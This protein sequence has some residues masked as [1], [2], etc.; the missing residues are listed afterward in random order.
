MKGTLFF[1]VSKMVTVMK[2]KRK[3]VVP[4]E[5]LCEYLKHTPFDQYLSP[6]TLT[7]F[8]SCFDGVIKSR[9]GK[10]IAL[11]SHKVYV[12]CQGEVDLSTVYPEVEGKVEAKGFLCRK[13]C[14]DIINVTQTEQDVKRRM[15]IKVGKAIDV[16]EEIITTGSGESDIILV[17]STMKALNDFTAVHPELAAPIKAICISSIEDR[18][19]TIS[20]LEG[21][22]RSKLNVLAAMCRY[23]AFDAN[24]VVFN[25]NSVGTKLYLVLSG[26]A[27]VVAKDKLS[28]S[29]DVSSLSRP[30]SSYK[31][32]IE[33]SIVLQRSFECGG[34]QTPLLSSAGEVTIAELSTGSFFGETALVF[35][36]GRTCSVKTSE[37]SLFLT[38]DR[39][40]FRNFLRICSTIEATLTTSIKKR[41]VS[42]LSSLGIPFLTGIPEE[43]LTSLATS[44]S[45]QE[46]PMDHIIFRQGDVGDAFYIIVHGSVRVETNHDEGT[47]LGTLGPGQYFG[48]MSILFSDE[49]TRNATVVVSSDKAILL[50]IDKDSFQRIFVSSNNPVLAAEFE[51]R[52][53][54]HSANLKHILAHP[55][56]VTSFRDFL[57]KEHAG[58][59]IDFWSAVE[60]F[61]TCTCESTRM[62]KAASIWLL[63][64]ADYA[65]RQVNLPHSISSKLDDFINTKNEFEPGLFD[66]AK[67]EISKL[68]ERDN[69]ARYKKSTEF[70]DFMS[71]LGILM[72]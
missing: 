59:N 25:E 47:N 33:K 39:T 38:I 42:K 1:S 37:K 32:A 52:V 71:R 28:S 65:D 3:A 63:F 41:M 57:E 18:L 22:P 12:V 31:R 49:H 58:E 15:T 4:L 11:D 67:K 54:K 43:M 2:I 16:A 20:F 6:V 66:E 10:E 21:I 24:Q 17:S 69:F 30:T 9:P 27:L 51:L 29:R 36:I 72:L 40:D 26:T 56:G 61:A 35:D 7:E 48:E 34:N 8:A 60:D 44:V 14:G 64:C 19:L 5:T 50:S 55:L 46:V 53:L 13:R 62:E 70:S 45:I 68:M 23:E